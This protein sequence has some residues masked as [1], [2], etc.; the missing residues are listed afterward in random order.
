MASTIPFVDTVEVLSDSEEDQLVEK[1]EK[2]RSKWI[3]RGVQFSTTTIP[4]YVSYYCTS[5]LKIPSQFSDTI[6]P[7]ADIPVTVFLSRVLPK[8]SQAMIFPS[9]DQYICHEP[10]NTDGLRLQFL[11]LPPWTAVEKLRKPE[12][13]E[14]KILDGIQSITNPMYPGDRFPLWTVAAWFQ[15]YEVADKQKRWRKCSQWLLEHARLPNATQPIVLEAQRWMGVLGWNEVIK[16]QGSGTGDTTVE[17]SRLVS[18]S[19]ISGTLIDL[20]CH[21][22]RE[23]LEC[24]EKHDSEFHIVP[25]TFIHDINRAKEKTDHL[26]PLTKYLSRLEARLKQLEIRYLVFPVFN[27]QAEHWLAFRV[28]FHQKVITYGDS[29]A[30]QGLMPPKSVL[31]KLKWWLDSRFG[32]EFEVVGDGLE[33]GMQDDL[34]VCGM[35]AINT[36]ARH[37]LGDPLWTVSRKTFDRTHWFVELCKAHTITTPGTS[38]GS[39]SQPETAAKEL[40]CVPL[41]PALDTNVTTTKPVLKADAV[42]TPSGGSEA[43]ITEVEVEIVHSD[44]EY[45][46]KEDGKRGIG[47]VD[48][49]PSSP[50]SKKVCSMDGDSHVTPVT[51]DAPLST[52]ITQSDVSDDSDATSDE[53]V[54]DSNTIN[55]VK[56]L[57]VFG[58][59]KSATW[60]RA[61]RTLYKANPEQFS[62]TN[63]DSKRFEAFKTRIH[64]LGAAAEVIDA[65]NVRHVDCGETYLMKEPFNTGNFKKHLGTCKK[66]KKSAGTRRLDNFFGPSKKSAFPTTPSASLSTPQPAQVACPGLPASKNPLIAMYIDRTGA[67]GGGGR[68]VNSISREVYGK[69]YKFLSPSR[70]HSVKRLQRLSHRWRID[71]DVQAVFSSNCLKVVFVDPSAPTQ[72]PR[73]CP[74]CHA[75]GRLKTLKKAVKIARPPNANYKFL[76]HEYQNKSVGSLLARVKGLETLVNSENSTTTA[77]ALYTAEV[78]EGKHKGSQPDMFFGSLLQVMVVKRNKVDKG[79][80]MQN[81]QYAPDIIQLA[82]IIQMHSTVA[83]EFLREYLPLPTVR[84]LRRY[85]EKEPSFPLDI[86]AETFKRAAH[87]LDIMNWDGPV[88]I[89]CDDTKL[90]P[91]LRPYYN[92]AEDQYYL[93]GAVGKPLVLASPDDFRRVVTQGLAEKATKLRLFCMQIALPGVPS[94]ILAAKAIPSS[95]NAATLTEYSWEI[96]SG[97][98]E[99]GIKVCSYACDGAAT[100]RSVQ[101]NLR[102]KASTTRVV[103]IP[104][105]GREEE[106]IEIRVHFYGKD[107]IA[108]IQDPKHA[109]KT[110]RNNLYS[111]SKCLTF[112]HD[113]AMYSQV[114]DM[115]HKGC[116]IRYR[117]WHRY[118]KQ[119]DSAATR[120][121]SSATL[122]WLVENESTSHLALIIYLFVFGELVDAY[123]NRSINIRTR[124]RMV[125][126]AYF[127]LE[128]WIQFLRS[129]NYPLRKHCLSHEAIDIINT[130]VH[131][132]LESVIIYRDHV[133]G[134]KPLLPWRMGSGPCERVFGKCRRLVKDFMM[135]QFF[136]MVPKLFI[137]LREEALATR[138]SDGKES[139]SGYSHTDL[140]CRGSDLH[141]L[142]LMPSDQ[143]I[144]EEAESAWADSESLWA[145]LGSTAADIHSQESPSIPHILSWFSVN[146]SRGT[147]TE[148]DPDSDS[149]SDS[150]SDDDVD[151]SEDS[152][153]FE[154]KFTSI[155]DAL[156][157]FDRETN[158]NPTQEQRASSLRFAAISQY[159][160]QHMKIQALPELDEEGVT[161]ALSD[162]AEYIAT[163]LA[164]SLPRVNNGSTTPSNPFQRTYTSSPDFSSADFSELVKQRQDHETLQAKTG[165]RKDKGKATTKNGSDSEEDQS[166]TPTG[167]KKREPS[168]RQKIMREFDEI[169]REQE[170]VR[171][172][173]GVERNLRWTGNGG[174]TSLGPVGNS[175]NAAAVATATAKTVK[176]RSASKNLGKINTG[177]P[178]LAKTLGT[179][180]IDSNTPLVV[181]L[182]KGSGHGFA[183]LEDNLVLCRVLEVYCKGG[184]KNGR[185]E[186]KSESSNIAAVS[187][188]VVQIFE[189][190]TGRMF[191]AVPAALA[192]SKLKAKRFSLL[193]S[194][195]FLCILADPPRVQGGNL[196]L[197]ARDWSMF[198]ALR[199][200]K[201][202]LK[203]ALAPKKRGT[204][205]A[206]GVSDQSEEE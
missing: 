182:T 165:V 151:D 83:Y 135:V 12:W 115:Y 38:R 87:H 140:D 132:F 70:K 80:G 125:L 178:G 45:V 127:F 106:P 166:M 153:W 50:P 162:D 187:Y 146:Q 54:L 186:S 3:G 48:V 139:A 101:R 168:I 110:V 142:S 117:D 157:A 124:V 21:Q 4:R 13:L 34:I 76:P 198:S 105:P 144:E 203:S 152:D 42:V 92:K 18:E 61:Q 156:D 97:L 90:T 176:T 49:E 59:S 129:V 81:F 30:H 111:G 108:F 205:A 8:P 93:V 188:L 193:S 10:P 62:K 158:L 163:M 128:T 189:V 31:R 65:M 181:S 55:F 19:K 160:D 206:D 136:E 137:G 56:S 204:K 63:A 2:S 121:T 46:K 145:V 107:P 77:C 52:T 95:L 171:V 69:K 191:R 113:V 149:M 57:R 154:S 41:A 5:Q 201:I 73:P 82:H 11:D 102:T 39:P 44:G 194:Q 66:R 170:V 40:P 131:G 36:I 26:Q 35:L 119:D 74:P 91:A 29:L 60:S 9:I 72:V 112:P 28:D 161:E 122:K 88:A 159:L 150:D 116:P 22:L 200:Q 58:S 123:E 138:F 68:T 173:S 143:E 202:A 180:G 47:E 172:G 169:N 94:I 43:M 179:A 174:G 78:L 109:L 164:D 141:V 183:F 64:A 167:K 104:H 120:L 147:R 14:Q 15:S 103:R 20:M 89:S 86:E 197:T 155:Q 32:G 134:Q 126:R 16:L 133:R 177:N 27:E 114:R 175:A 100:E 185:H 96:L 1:F 195:V 85:R 75:V 79:V 192:F 84:S 33:H 7:S 71:R 196:S 148:N 53:E 118:D 67:Q 184:G 190:W 98:L 51:L 6:F 23:R 199:D 24:D 17:F 99:K 25:R 37:C 130:L